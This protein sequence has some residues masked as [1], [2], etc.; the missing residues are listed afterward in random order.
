MK[1]S[2]TMLQTAES[3]ILLLA[4]KWNRYFNANYVREKVRAINKIYSTKLNRI[5]AGVG[6]ASMDLLFSIFQPIKVNQGHTCLSITHHSKTFQNDFYS[7][8]SSLLGWIFNIPF[9][10]LYYSTFKSNF[11]P[12]QHNKCGKG[13]ILLKRNWWEK[14]SQRKMCKNSFHLS[15]KTH[16]NLVLYWIFPIMVKPPSQS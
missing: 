15:R 12:S 3:Y 5:W 8:D 10:K 1:T 14:R 2:T 11:F 7:T 4:R 16:F 13:T 9:S 6:L